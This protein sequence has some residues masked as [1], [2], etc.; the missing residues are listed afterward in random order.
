MIKVSTKL[1]FAQNVRWIK[2]NKI[3]KN[4]YKVLNLREKKAKKPQKNT[5]KLKTHFAKTS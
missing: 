2:F 1:F 3:F 4:I 5:Q